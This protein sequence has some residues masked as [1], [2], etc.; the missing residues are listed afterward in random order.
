[1]GKYVLS[2]DKEQMEKEDGIL[3]FPRRFTRELKE[4]EYYPSHVG[5]D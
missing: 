4:E 3:H 5:I 2:F 1:M